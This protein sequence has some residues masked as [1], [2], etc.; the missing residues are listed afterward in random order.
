M[1]KLRIQLVH[2][3]PVIH[4]RVVFGNLAKML[5]PG[6][7]MMLTVIGESKHFNVLQELEKIDKWKQYIKN[8]DQYLFPYNSS[9]WPKDLLEKHLLDNHFNIHHIDIQ[10]KAYKF[11]KLDFESK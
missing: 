8:I 3:L 7:Q 11:A 6:G 5:K 1:I 2:T 10:R 9:D 4:F